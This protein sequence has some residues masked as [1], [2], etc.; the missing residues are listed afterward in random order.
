MTALAVTLVAIPACWR[1]PA[2]KPDATSSN[3]SP[4]VQAPPTSPPKPLGADFEPIGEERGVHD[5]ARRVRHRATGIELILVEPG[6]FTM[7]TP[8]SELERDGDEAE[9]EMAIAAP[10]YL[11]ETE[12]TSAV[13]EAVMGKKPREFD[14]DPTFPACG[15]SWRDAE[16]F[17]ARMNASGEGGWR[18]PTE[19]EWEYACRAGT[20]TPFSCGESITPE[21]A[22]FNGEHPYPPDGEKGL[23]REGPT[24]VKSFPPNPWGFYDMHGNVWEWCSEK[25]VAYPERGDV[26][27]PKPGASRVMKGGAFTS[28]GRQLRSGYRDGYP[29]KAST[30]AK[31]GFRLAKSLPE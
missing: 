18:M 28:R 30:G 19:A 31:Y 4:A 25:F 21:Q 5:L 13:W 23:N 8:R 26:A 6:R 7:G 29:P 2:A 11:A 17:I 10:F 22:N 1:R 27:S 15:V 3:A 24:P 16:A 20:T 14:T 9:R 12:T